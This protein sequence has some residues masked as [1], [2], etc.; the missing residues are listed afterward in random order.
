MATPDSY[1]SP[2]KVKYRPT[3][4]KDYAGRLMYPG[5]DDEFGK[6]RGYGNRNEVNMPFLISDVGN[7]RPA[8]LDSIKGDFYSSIAKPVPVIQP[9]AGHNIMATLQPDNLADPRFAIN[10]RSPQSL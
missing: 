2:S 8:G 10:H 4:Q 6:K 1:F 5:V 3:I 7:I 9:A